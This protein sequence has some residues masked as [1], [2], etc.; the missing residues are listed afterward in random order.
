V[1]LHTQNKYSKGRL[2]INGSARPRLGETTAHFVT[3]LVCV[4]LG[5]NFLY[6]A[7]SAMLVKAR[8]ID[9]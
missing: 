7:G 3:A 6:T 4:G 1:V 5:W 8:L 9:L 2:Y